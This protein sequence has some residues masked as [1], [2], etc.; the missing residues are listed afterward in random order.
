MAA[1]SAAAASLPQP[2]F[3]DAG[4]RRAHNQRIFGI[5][6]EVGKDGYS[7]NKKV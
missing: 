6:S 2:D 4:Q 3:A 5:Q 7:I 1:V